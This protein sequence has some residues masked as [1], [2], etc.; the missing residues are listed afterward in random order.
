MGMKPQ[1]R[2]GRAKDSIKIV[3]RNRGNITFIKKLAK[4]L[5][6]PL[7][8]IYDTLVNDVRKD[9]TFKQRVK[10]TW[11]ARYARPN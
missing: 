8:A 2:P 3:S 11:N 6:V 5:Q 4:D 7:G 1:L 9:P 10:E